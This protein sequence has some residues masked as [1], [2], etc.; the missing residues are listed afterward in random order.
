MER[1]RIT[2]YA[3]WQLA[4]ALVRA[5]ELSARRSLHLAK[6]IYTTVAGGGGC[7]DRITTRSAPTA[8]SE[9]ATVVCLARW[10]DPLELRTRGFGRPFRRRASRR[11]P[12]DAAPVRAGDVG[13]ILVAGRR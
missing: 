7:C 9:T 11:R 5:P 2:F 3:G 12:G 8:L 6:G 13:E 4:P 10:D 1:E